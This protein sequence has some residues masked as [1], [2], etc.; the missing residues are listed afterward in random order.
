MRNLIEVRKNMM[1]NPD[2]KITYAFLKYI[3]KRLG[4]TVEGLN[5]ALN[6]VYEQVRIH[7][8]RVITDSTYVTRAELAGIL[9]KLHEYSRLNHFQDYSIL[10][11]NYHKCAAEIGT[12]NKNSESKNWVVKALLLFVL[13]PLAQN[14]VN[15]IYPFIKNPI[16]RL[17]T[18]GK[19]IEHEPIKV[20][21]ARDENSK[22]TIFESRIIEL[23]VKE[24]FEDWYHVLICSEDTIIDGYLKKEDIQN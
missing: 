21:K 9:H 23:I 12:G 17:V 24:E 2:D 22:Y 15:D 4:F 5:H 8:G 18:A 10:V 6:Y 20:Y 3:I 13:S 7:E 19:K 14:V 1:S 11:E 16:V